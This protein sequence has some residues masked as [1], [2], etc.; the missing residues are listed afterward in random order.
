MTMTTTTTHDGQFMIAQALWDLYQMCM[1]IGDR[2]PG[3]RQS[4]HAQCFY[5]PS[6]EYRQQTL[7]KC[8]F[9]SDVK[10]YVYR[11]QISSF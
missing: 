1:G 2:D 11:L 10:V 8:M 9:A 3:Y 7:W 5:L 6:G 4:K